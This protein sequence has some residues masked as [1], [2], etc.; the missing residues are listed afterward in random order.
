MV[1]VS[2]TWRIF[3]T[4]DL[5]SSTFGWHFSHWITQFSVLIPFMQNLISNL[6][7]KLDSK[8]LKLL[9]PFMQ[10]FSSILTRTRTSRDFF[11][12]QH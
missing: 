3:L 9:I 11:I 8:L 1:A 2:V 10:N 6:I 7:P 12:G 4:P 5:N